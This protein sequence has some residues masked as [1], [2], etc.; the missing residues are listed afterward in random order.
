MDVAFWMREPVADEQP[1]IH[2]IRDVDPSKCGA[3]AFAIL[4]PTSPFRTAATISRAYER[5][6]KLEVHSMRAVEPVKQ[7]PGK[8][9]FH[10]GPGYPMTPVCDASRSD[11]TPWHSS[12][13]QTLPPV[14]VQNASLEMAWTYV[15]KQF[16]TIAGR[17]IAPFFT[18]GYEGLDLNT[19]DDWRE[20]ERLI[21]EGLV[22]LPSLTVGAQTPA[23]HSL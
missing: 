18:E 23:T 20:A 6:R 10:N 13:T 1:D 3:D 4:R 8:M 11:G 12:P 17:K 7:H 19:L 14:Y 5:F 2:W 21:A 9:W 15:V 16:G 22:D